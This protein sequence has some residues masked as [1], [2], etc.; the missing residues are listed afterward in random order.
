MEA[1]SESGFDMPWTLRTLNIPITASNR[2]VQN[3]ILP[4]MR[5]KFMLERVCSARRSLVRSAPSPLRVA[6]AASNATSQPISRIASAPRML[7]R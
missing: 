5:S 4:A 6:A 2:M 1:S 7:G 3:T